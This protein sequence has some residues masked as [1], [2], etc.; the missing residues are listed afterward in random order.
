MGGGRREGEVEE[1]AEEEE[2]NRE[3]REGNEKKG[4]K[5]CLREEELRKSVIALKANQEQELQQHQ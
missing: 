2:G 3:W 5:G 4:G 1:R